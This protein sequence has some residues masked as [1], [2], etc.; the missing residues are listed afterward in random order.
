MGRVEKNIT[1]AVV[2]RLSIPSVVLKN[3]PIDRWLAFGI[4]IV[5]VAL[6]LLPKSPLIIVVC[7]AIIFALAFHPIWNFWWVEKAMPRRIG[8]LMVV[9]VGLIFLGYV[10]WDAS[11]KLTFKEAPQF[12]WWRRQ[13][14]SH[15]IT[16]FKNYLISLSIEVPNV[17][18]P[19]TIDGN[20]GNG[21]GE[22]VPV[23]LPKYR[24]N[25]GIG[26]FRVGDRTA[27]TYEYGA[28]IIHQKFNESKINEDEGIHNIMFGFLASTE[29]NEYFNSSYWGEKPQW[30][31]AKI[32]WDIR[33]RLGQQFT[34]RLGA[35]TLMVI[36][37][38]PEEGRNDN[39]DVE[40]WRKVRI[41]DGI[42]ESSSD[43]WT[44]ILEILKKDGQPVDSL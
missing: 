12:T 2:A 40:F 44:Q 20:N 24:G 9:L 22:G 11:I 32:L 43:K 33:C 19:F 28:Y 8:V 41:A 29:L 38:S 6:Y 13:I 27:A 42:V 7:L 23:G 37:D 18:P 3:K 25:I 16:G 31:H 14:I 39:F 17:I 10:S 35:S 26:K 30:L 4:A 21:G 34:D 5:S 1:D 15:D 36:A